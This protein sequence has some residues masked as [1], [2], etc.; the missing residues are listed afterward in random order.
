V[1][2]KN[3]ILRV[4]LFCALFLALIFFGSGSLN[5]QETLKRAEKLIS[6]MRSSLDN[7]ALE[8]RKATEKSDV[9][10]VNC[11]KQKERAMKNY[12]NASLRNQE[13][14][15]A[16]VK[17][18]DS[19]EEKRFFK[20]IEL[21]HKNVK[22]IEEKLKECKRGEEGERRTK[23]TVIKPEGGLQEEQI[24]EIFP[25]GTVEGESPDG[26]PPVPP[27]SPYR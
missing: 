8:I 15:R 26:Y 27:A 4:R 16:A 17:V 7:V 10:L 13:N 12:V 14:L 1:D 22:E 5:A 25:E 2:Y 21:A 18:R 9:S 20:L 23:V 11:L 24:D 3:V 6:S 19:K